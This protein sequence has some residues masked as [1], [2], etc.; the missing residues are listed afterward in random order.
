MFNVFDNEPDNESM[1]LNQLA[2]QMGRYPEYNPLKFKLL[3]M[4][5]IEY[6]GLVPQKLLTDFKWSRILHNRAEAIKN[7]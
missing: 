6:S 5:W 2:K 4:L 7:Q 3:S 1:R